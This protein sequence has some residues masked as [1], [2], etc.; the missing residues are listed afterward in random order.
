MSSYLAKLRDNEPVRLILW[1]ALA[2]L[3]GWLVTKGV[4]GTDAADLITAGA[5]LILGG[6][7]I[8]AARTRVTAGAH[9]TDAVTATIDHVRDRVADSLGQPGVDALAHLEEMLQAVAEGR[10]QHAE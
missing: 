10:G 9:V 7:G 1:P 2:I 8:E 4:I 3:T 5:L 6:G